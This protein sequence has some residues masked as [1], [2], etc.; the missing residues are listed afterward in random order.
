[1]TTMYPDEAGM[2]KEVTAGDQ[3]RRRQVVVGRLPCASVCHNWEGQRGRGGSCCFGF[4]QDR[5]VIGC[6]DVQA[7]INAFSKLNVR[8][9]ELEDDLKVKKVRTRFHE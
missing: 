7:D 6:V 9:H 4:C 1:M 2:D 5:V 3:V 8:Y